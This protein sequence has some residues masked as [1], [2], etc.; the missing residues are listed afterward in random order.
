M[1]A[2]RLAVWLLQDSID[3]GHTKLLEIFIGIAAFALLMQAIAV[4][5]VAAAGYKAQKR[6]MEIVEEVRAKALPLIDKSHGLV[7]KSQA[8]MA[9]LTPKI[10]TITANV[11]QVSTII[12]DKVVEFEPTVSAANA[13]VQDANAKT[14]QQIIRVNGMVTSALNATAE[15]ASTIHEGIRTPAREIAGVVSGL[16]AGIDSLISKTR[17]F[18]AGIKP[19]P[20]RRPGPVV[21]KTAN[22]Y[23]Q[24]ESSTSAQVKAAASAFERAEKS[25]LDL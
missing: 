4:I 22:P 12:K 19:N 14:H 10:Q 21:V 15:L 24:A 17:G 25:D 16:K 2:K 13:T 23:Y 11:E 3:S 8:L 9:D 1:S 7:E 18:G 5:V 20:V 6:A